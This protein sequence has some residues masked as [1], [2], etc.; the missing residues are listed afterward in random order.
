MVTISYTLPKKYLFEKRKDN[1]PLTKLYKNARSVLAQVKLLLLKGGVNRT[2]NF[3]IEAYMRNYSISNLEWY[4]KVT[5][6]NLRREGKNI[7]MGNGLLYNSAQTQIRSHLLDQLNCTSVLDIGAGRGDNI[8]ALAAFNPHLKELIGLELTENGYKRALEW[9]DDIMKSNMELV[10]LGEDLKKIDFN[11]IRFLNAT[12]TA[13]PLPDK[14]VDASYTHLVLEQIPDKYPKVLQEM[15]R[16]TRKYCFFVESFTESL[17]FSDKINLKNRDYFRFSY[18]T[19]EKYGL[20]PIYFTTSFIKKLK[21]GTGL[22]V[23]KVM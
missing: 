21:F 10:G 19:F 20:R 1:S 3:V 6:K 23:A 13:I 14:S 5:V 7:I 8:V 4:K 12:A 22:L 16:V 11:K 17:T 2:E 15:R 18:K 9:K